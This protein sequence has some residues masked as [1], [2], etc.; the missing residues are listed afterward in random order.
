M[1]TKEHEPKAEMNGMEVLAAR[2]LD[3]FVQYSECREG[4]GFPITRTARIFLSAA[5]NAANRS[6]CPE[7]GESGDEDEIA[8]YYGG[9]VD[10]FMEEVAELRDDFLERG[11]EVRRRRSVENGH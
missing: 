3:D 5:E 1:E 6:F 10:A 8:D 2:M 7:C 9:I 4:D 11:R